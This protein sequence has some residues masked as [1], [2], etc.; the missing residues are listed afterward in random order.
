MADYGDSELGME[1]SD[2]PSLSLAI[3]SLGR[4]LR[5][6]NLFGFSR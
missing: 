2:S 3:G 1:W 4:E 5:E 6:K